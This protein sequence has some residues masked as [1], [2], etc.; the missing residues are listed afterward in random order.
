[1]GKVSIGRKV[2]DFSLSATGDQTVTLSD[3]LNHDWRDLPVYRIDIEGLN[4]QPLNFQ[5]AG[6]LMYLQEV[7]GKQGWQPAP[8]IGVL[9]AMNWLAPHPESASLPILSQVHDGEHQKL[10]LTR[11]E[12][13]TN[14]LTVL[15]VWPANVETTDGSTRIWVGTASYLSVDNSLPMIAYG[16]YLMVTALRRP[17][18]VA[19]PA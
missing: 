18:A 16:I 8:Q 15:R 3:W 10:L 6:T 9:R 11:K 2:P 14:R 12:P 19:D 4:T 1:M 13:A 17:L 5:W 7:L